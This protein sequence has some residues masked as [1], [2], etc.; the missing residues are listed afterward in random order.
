MMSAE[1]EKWRVSTIE[2]VFETDLETLKQWIHEGCVLPTDKVSKGNLNWIDAGR[3]PM[4]RATFNGEVP[5][6]PT[7][8]T[9]PSLTETSAT[10]L[11]DQHLQNQPDDFELHL[12]EIA[13]LPVNRA[14]A[15][16]TDV[17]ANHPGKAA[18]HIC[19]GCAT[20][21]CEECP[22]YVGTSKIAVCPL[23]GELCS[24]YEK[25][26]SKAVHQEFQGSGF[27]LDDLGRALRYPLQ[28]KVALLFGAAFYGFCLLAGLRP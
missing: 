20:A 1:V 22:K 24:L 11:P 18:K 21:F 10:P 19:R 15:A 14:P 7:V 2:G 23:C 13:P 3:A 28:H 16:S 6:P 27:G 26:R 9:E 5:A 4:L 17:C 8:A 12:A 25:Q